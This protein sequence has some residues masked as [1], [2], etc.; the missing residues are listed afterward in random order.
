MSNN[1]TVIPGIGE[2]APRDFKTQT[3]SPQPEVYKGT[4]FPGMSNMAHPG[5]HPG[6]VKTENHKPIM[7]FLYS[8]S[9]TGSGEYWPLYLGL[10][11]IG[12]SATNSVHLAEA[13]VSEKHAEIVIRQMKNPDG[14]IASIQDSRSTCGT[15]INGSSLGF[16]PRECHNGDIIT[17][18]EHYELFFVLINAKELNLEPVEGFVS[19]G[20]APAN[21]PVA[22][23][24]VAAQ[25]Q[26]TP[27]VSYNTPSASSSS[28]STIIMPVRK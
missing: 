2:T 1:K 15:L 9:R 26:P 17:I 4:Q 13:T 11:T 20:A 18:G 28:N 6:T 25:P 24:G 7:G 8:V 12:R 23:P 14:V 10:N 27:M 16:E 21:N 22:F 5:T 3:I 19:A